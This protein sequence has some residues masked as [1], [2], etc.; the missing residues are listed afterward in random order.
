MSPTTHHLAVVYECVECD[1]RYLG[2]RQCPDC[3][4]FTRRIGLGGTCPSCAEQILVTELDPENAPRQE[5]V[6]IR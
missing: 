4:L 1:A 6:H 5:V 3:H 2:D